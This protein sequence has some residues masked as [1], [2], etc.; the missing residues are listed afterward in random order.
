MLAAPLCA[1]RRGESREVP[2]EAGCGVAVEA[3][4]DAEEV[5][6]APVQGRWSLR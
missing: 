1:E 3:E 2:L 4:E 5:G 6:G